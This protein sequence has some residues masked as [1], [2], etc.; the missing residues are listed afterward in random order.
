MRENELFYEQGRLTG[1]GLSLAPEDDFELFS[2]DGHLSDD[3]LRA[4]T[5][6]R[7]DELERLEAAEH[8]G[9]CGRCMERY[10]A[11]LTGGALSE[12]ETDLVL[13]VAR[14][15]R[16]KSRRLTVRRYAAATAAAALALTFWGSGVFTQM[17]PQKVELREPTPE[18]VRTD[19]LGSQLSDTLSGMLWAAGDWCGG[20]IGSRQAE[21]A[22]PAAP[23]DAGLDAQTPPTGQDA[24]EQQPDTGTDSG[25]AVR[26]DQDAGTRSESGRRGS[27]WFDRE[28]DTF[29]P[30][31]R[32]A[33]D[34]IQ[35]P[36]REPASAMRGAA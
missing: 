11:L 1:E 3:G 5:E 36:A 34:T 30:D 13:P 8:L 19:S 27:G 10:T 21:P 32:F 16:E 12:P 29:P 18:P 17:V 23:G 33:E 6:G 20:I 28:E 25:A 14:R 7:L 9:F 22:A 31:G 4:L 15:V 26:R 2:D 35:I 24:P